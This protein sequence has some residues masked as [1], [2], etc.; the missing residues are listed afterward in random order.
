MCL[1]AV[2][3]AKIPE[4]HYA[5]TPDDAAAVG[6]D[7]RFIYDFIRGMAKEEKVKLV[8]TPTENQNTPFERYHQLVKGQESQLY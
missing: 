8:H 2:H 6:F 4:C 7:D 1:G 3:W 5:C